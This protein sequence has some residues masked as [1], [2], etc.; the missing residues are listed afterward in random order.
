MCRSTDVELEVPH[1]DAGEESHVPRS[2]LMRE[3]TSCGLRLPDPARE[4]MRHKTVHVCQEPPAA[5]HSISTQFMVAPSARC[6]SCLND[7]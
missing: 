4:K 1:V 3:N 2:V 7:L 6:T 5:F